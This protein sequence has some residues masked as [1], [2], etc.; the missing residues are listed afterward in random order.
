M[1]F[2]QLRMHATVAI[3]LFFNKISEVK[4]LRVKNLADNNMT[5]PKSMQYNINVQ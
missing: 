3:K 4:R 1:K 5:R 2:A